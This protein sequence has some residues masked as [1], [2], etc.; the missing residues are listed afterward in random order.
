MLLGAQSISPIKGSS[1]MVVNFMDFAVSQTQIQF[2]LLLISCVT[3][4]DFLF[5]KM[6]IK[7]VF[8]SLMV[9]V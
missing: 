2:L 4:A 3:L 5:C 1:Y 6:K 9:N 8:T 7:K